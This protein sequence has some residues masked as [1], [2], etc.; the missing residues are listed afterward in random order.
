M[1]ILSNKRITDV[2]NAKIRDLATQLIIDNYK[3]F[4]V[5]FSTA[6]PKDT[7]R[8]FIDVDHSLLELIHHTNFNLD[9]FQKRYGD[10]IKNSVFII[11][12]QDETIINNIEELQKNFDAIKVENI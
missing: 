4:F 6:L 1:F 11:E 2:S 8:V 7:K 9:D 3:V 10:F 12:H 5:D